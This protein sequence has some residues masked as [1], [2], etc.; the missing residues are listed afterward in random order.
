M[1]RAGTIKAARLLLRPPVAA[2][3]NQI[4]DRYAGDPEVCEF[5]NLQP[6]VA[7]DLVCYSCAGEA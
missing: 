6:G 1:R 5:P 2:D 3:A 7:L 4:F